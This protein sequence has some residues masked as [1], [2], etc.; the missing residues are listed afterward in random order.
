[1]ISLIIDCDEHQKILCVL[2]KGRFSG[3]VAVSENCVVSSSALIMRHAIT[4]A[5]GILNP[6][7]KQLITDVK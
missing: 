1:M 4:C 2:V 6:Q 7:G 5:S 3:W